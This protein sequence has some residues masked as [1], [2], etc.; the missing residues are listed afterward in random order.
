MKRFNRRHVLRSGMA[1]SAMSVAAPFVRAKQAEKTL[2]FVAEA[3]LKVFDPVW[4]T[5]YIT[6][7]HGYLIYDTLFG[8]DETLQIKPQMIDRV[9]SFGMMGNQ[10]CHALPEQ[11]HRSQ[12]SND[13][14]LPRRMAR[15]S[16]DATD[17]LRRLRSLSSNACG[18]GHVRVSYHARVRKSEGILGR[19]IE[20]K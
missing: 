14:A 11:P 13:M 17:H 8:T 6:R 5:G 9:N 20:S 12:G 18:I 16:T 4:T 1:A 19:C 15:S 2:R 7:N 10:W 3:D